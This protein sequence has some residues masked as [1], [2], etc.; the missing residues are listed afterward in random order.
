[1]LTRKPQD[2]AHLFRAHFRDFNLAYG[3]RDA[4][5]PA[6][7]GVVPLLLWRIGAEARKWVDPEALAEQ[8]LPDSLRNDPEDPAMFSDR[9]VSRC[10]RRVVEPLVGFGLLEERVVSHSDERWWKRQVEVRVAQLFDH[11]LR[12]RWD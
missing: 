12:F 4:G 9:G 2:L 7:Q 10:R 8:V 5:A 3:D 11:L 6:L 1:M